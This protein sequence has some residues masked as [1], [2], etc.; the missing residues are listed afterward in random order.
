MT[1]T[2][3]K[4]L[5]AR[6]STGLSSWMRDGRGS[7]SIEFVFAAILIVTT[8]VGGMDLYRVVDAQSVALRAAST[9]AGY[10][11]HERAP[12]ATF[13]EDLAKFSYR[14][15]IA[16]PSEAAFVVSAVSRSD[17]TPEE[18]DPPTVVEWNRA[19]A[20]GE[21][22]GSPPD[23]LGKSCGR[24]SGKPA[25]LTALGIVPG[26]LVVVVEVCVKLLPRAFV[27]GRLLA[28]NVF[29]TLYYQ[30]RVLPVRSETMQEPS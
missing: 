6:L 27:G 22:P 21:D 29:P 11:S 19:F 28:D 17:A 26:E 25:M 18:P 3:A 8:T 10:L 30:H 13:I 14:N 16:L 20:V 24:L 7:V 5:A 9:V 15:E 1:S 2:L 12:R 23:D 4:D